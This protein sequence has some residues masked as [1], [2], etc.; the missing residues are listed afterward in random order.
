M[1]EDSQVTIS[2]V[3][4]ALKD[5]CD[6][7]I[8]ETIGG[9]LEAIAKHSFDLILLDINLPDGNG[10]DAYAKIRELEH[11]KLTP[12]LFLTARIELED[13]VRGFSLGADDY[14]VK[15]FD[16]VELK[17]RIAAKLKNLSARKSASEITFGPFEVSVAAQRVSVKDETGSGRKLE[18]TSSQFKLLFHLLRNENRTV[19]RDEILKEVWGSEVNVSDRT[20]DTHVYAIRREL[21]SL[22]KLLLSVHGKGYRLTLPEGTRNP[23]A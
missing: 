6:L 11:Y 16:L 19:S 22:K 12:I 8:A 20:V 1:V 17:M 3:K 2:I 23:A 5:V 4:A 13:K 7:T 18:L 15:P 14:I 21:G 10:F 9:G